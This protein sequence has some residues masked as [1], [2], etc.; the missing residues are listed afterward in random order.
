MIKRLWRKFLRFFRRKTVFSSDGAPIAGSMGMAPMVAY[1]WTGA[2]MIRFPDPGTLP[3]GTGDG[4][5]FS[6]DNEHIVIAHDITQDYAITNSQ[7]F[8]NVLI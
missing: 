6:P 5:A 7:T 4:V 8:G 1:P 2:F 3:A